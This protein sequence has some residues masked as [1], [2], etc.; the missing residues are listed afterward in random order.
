MSEVR[1]YLYDSVGSDKE[2]L[3]DDIDAAIPGEKQLLW[4]NLLRRDT[5][6]L[7][8]IATRLGL[9]DVPIQKIIDESGRPDIDSFKDFFRFSMDSVVTEKNLP[10]EKIKVDFIVGKNCV[11]TVHEGEIGYFNEFREREK[12]ETQFGELDAESF[13]ATLI[14]LNI[15]SYF[16]A[17]DELERQI[18]KVDQRILRSDLGTEEF[19]DEMIRLRKSASKLRRWLT[20]HRKIIYALSRAD[21]RQ[22]AESDSFE[23]FKALNQHFES[24]MEAV[25]NSR[26]TVLGVFD[27]YATKS[28]Q[29]TNFFVKRLTFL[30][31]ITGS[32]SVIAGVLGMNYR[33]DF[34]DAPGGFWLTVAGMVMV[35]I[36][37]TIVARLKRWI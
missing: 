34:F 13:V 36:G 31:L 3:L 17:I 23:Q 16:H 5:R 11:V 14:D 28:A 10:P 32:L 20:P 18:D 24:A 35:A 9:T 19:L 4:V 22:I 30:T 8:A 6:Q 33:A 15:V 25:Q 29:M 27:L 1:L 26:E 7:T 12:G 2:I 21:F 37:L